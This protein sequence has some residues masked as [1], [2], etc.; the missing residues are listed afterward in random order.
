MIPNLNPSWSVHA[1]GEQT[2][3]GTIATLSPQSVNIISIIRTAIGVYD[4]IL[5]TPLAPADSILV[6]SFRLAI[7]GTFIFPIAARDTNLIR[8]INT[9]DGALTPR[10]RTFEFIIFR[11]GTV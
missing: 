4:I 1:A 3:N 5:G 8:G 7:D 9:V 11:F 6:S 10:D 2:S